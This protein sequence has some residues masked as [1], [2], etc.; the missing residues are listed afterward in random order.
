MPARGVAIYNWQSDP[1]LLL[2][3]LDAPLL[4]SSNLDGSG[5]Y[6]QCGISPVSICVVGIKC[7]HT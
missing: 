1:S 4:M 6:D 5:R 2:M 3:F 7:C